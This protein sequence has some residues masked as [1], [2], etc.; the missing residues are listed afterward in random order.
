MSLL[1][2]DLPRALPC[3]RG[4]TVDLDLLEIT[5]CLRAIVAAEPREPVRSE[6]AG[7]L[8]CLAEHHPEHARELQ[9]TASTLRHPAGRRP[10]TDH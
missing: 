2:R 3:D 4:N 8:D 7:L 9:K 1:P 10:S 5:R 6:I